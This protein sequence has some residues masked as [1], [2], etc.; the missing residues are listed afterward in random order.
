MG[1]DQGIEPGEDY[2]PELEVSAVEELLLFLGGVSKCKYCKHEI[3]MV[4]RGD[5]VILFERDG[6][7]HDPICPAEIRRHTIA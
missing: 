6:R 3:I 5:E 4:M 7:L 2:D 1:E